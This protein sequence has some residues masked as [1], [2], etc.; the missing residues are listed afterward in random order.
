M[1][2]G[3]RRALLA[4]LLTATVALTGC[5]RKPEIA[6]ETQETSNGFRIGY[7]EGLTAVE[8]PDA[9]QHAVDEMIEKGKE[10]VGLEYKNQAFSTNGIDFECYIANAQRNEYDMFIA[11]YG[12]QELTDELFLSGLMPPGS[13]FDHLTL[14]HALEPG[15]NTVYVAFT[16]ITEADGEQAIHAQVLVT[17]I[18]NVT[19]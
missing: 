5:A 19:E 14:N 2:Y 16:Q 18:F 17:M 1:T 3:L 11:I 15:A 12:D 7:Q 9:L 13:A 8:D 10:T 4:L 6:P